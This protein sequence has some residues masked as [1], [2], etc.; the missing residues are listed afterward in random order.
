M[1]LVIGFFSLIVGVKLDRWRSDAGIE[2]TTARQST[3]LVAATLGLVALPSAL[4][5]SSSAACGSLS[6]PWSSWPGW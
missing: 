3:A 6:E 4:R 2:P 5:S 1:A